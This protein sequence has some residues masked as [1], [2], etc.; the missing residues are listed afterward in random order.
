MYMAPRYSLS[1]C[2]V[3]I[4][5]GRAGVHATLRAM[6]S[7]VTQWR[8]DP[9]V[10]SAARTVVFY[11]LNKDEMSEARALYHFVRSHVRYVRDVLDTETLATPLATMESR[12][13][14][15][16][17]HATLLA[18]LYEA[19]GFPTRFVI[20]GYHAPGEYEHVY[21]QVMVWGEWV[22]VD[23]TEPEYFGWEPE[24]PVIRYVEGE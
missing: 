23:T 15:C 6:R 2:L 7:L 13:G 10:V 3:R 14:D 8:A 18:T 9:R 17:D 4:P 16:D 11:E 19:I 20:A 24:S 1:G 5:G 12:G 22:S 21:L